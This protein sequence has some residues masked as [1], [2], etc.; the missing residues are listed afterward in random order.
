LPI[1]N[2]PLINILKEDSIVAYLGTTP[3]GKDDVPECGPWPWFVVDNTGG[4]PVL[5]CDVQGF[6][7]VKP[8]WLHPKFMWFRGSGGVQWAHD[9]VA[10]II[11]ELAYCMPASA[12]LVERKYLAKFQP[13]NC[14]VGSIFL[15]EFSKAGIWV[16]ASKMIRDQRL[17]PRPS[18]LDVKADEDFVSR[19]HD[20]CVSICIRIGVVSYADDEEYMAAVRRSKPLNPQGG[21][22]LSLIGNERVAGHKAECWPLLISLAVRMEIA[23]RVAADLSPEQIPYFLRLAF[24][25]RSRQDGGIEKPRVLY[26]GPGTIYP[27][28][29]GVLDP[30]SKAFKRHFEEF[31]YFPFSASTYLSEHDGW[32]VSSDYHRYDQSIPGDVITQIVF[33]VCEVLHVPRHVKICLAAFLRYAP[34][35]WAVDEEVFVIDKD[36]INPS[37]AGL[38]VAINHLWAE[39]SQ[40]LAILRVAS[41]FGAVKHAIPLK[42]GDDV[43]LCIEE[44]RARVDFVVS[45]MREVFEMWGIGWTTDSIS[46]NYA[47][48]LRKHFVKRAGIWY[49]YPVLSSRVRNLVLPER[50]EPTSWYNGKNMSR[51]ERVNTALAMRVQF[52][53]LANIAR[54]FWVSAKIN[55]HWGAAAKLL[56]ELIKQLVDKAKPFLLENE[57]D[58]AL[59]AEADPELKEKYVLLGI[60]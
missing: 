45:H 49:S 31:G 50:T 52:Y 37:G 44:C 42:F 56:N 21:V 54:Q 13:R 39:I 38:F 15:S 14:T 2:S 55:A 57:P 12:I 17:G 30:L 19:V 58:E 34:I 16:G 10:S 36:G 51:T 4:E 22:A 53:Q 33:A 11:K 27:L 59:V 1:I 32:I 18:W 35:V 8:L 41:V 29:Q 3:F 25:P 28:E 9:A 60:D 5:V 24:V 46:E 26:M 23:M 47:T 40:E 43:L 48:Y 7:F 20:M 6:A